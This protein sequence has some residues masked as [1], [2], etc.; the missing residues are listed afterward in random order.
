M[1]DSRFVDAFE[2]SVVASLLEFD[3]VAEDGAEDLLKR[4][5]F[6]ELRWIAVAGAVDVVDDD[7]KLLLK[8]I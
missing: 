5:I 1:G 2:G 4:V 7:D 3:A 8:L 6:L